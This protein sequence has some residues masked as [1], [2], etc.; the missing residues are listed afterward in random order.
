MVKEENL[1]NVTEAASYMGIKR[2]TIMQYTSRKVLRVYYRKR[3]PHYDVNDL[4][5]YMNKKRKNEKAYQYLDSLKAEFIKYILKDFN[6]K[7]EEELK[8][9]QGIIKKFKDIIV[10]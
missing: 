10:E 9:A 7:D 1:L 6:L 3:R 5:I 2:E 4:E 8:I